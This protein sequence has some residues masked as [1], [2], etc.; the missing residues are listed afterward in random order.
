MGNL[1]DEDAF[2]TSPEYELLKRGSINEDADVAVDCADADGVIVMVQMGA[3]NGKLVE[4]ALDL[5][6]KQQCNVLGALLYDGDAALLKMYYFEPL[7]FGSK[8]E[9][10]EEEEESEETFKLDDIF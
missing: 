4:R 3:H 7:P 2:Y 9:K 10:E 5:L 1:K 8:A 6:V